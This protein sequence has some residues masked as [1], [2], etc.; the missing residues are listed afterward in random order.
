MSKCS[1]CQYCFPCKSA[2]RSAA[3]PLIL[4]EGRALH[5]LTFILETSVGFRHCLLSIPHDLILAIL[6]K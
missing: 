5:T 3:L 2:A 4:C 6:G 1:E